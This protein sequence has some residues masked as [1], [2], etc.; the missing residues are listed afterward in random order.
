MFPP[1]GGPL[2]QCCELSGGVQAYT[3]YIDE[4][5]PATVGTINLDPGEEV[6]GVEE[7]EVPQTRSMA[8][9]PGHRHG[10]VHSAARPRYERPSSCSTSTGNGSGYRRHQLVTCSIAAAVTAGVAG[11][12][13]RSR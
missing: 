11:R 1:P 8:V 6:V 12:C 5:T 9:R 10:L 2:R 4:K 13:R 3:Y 7:P